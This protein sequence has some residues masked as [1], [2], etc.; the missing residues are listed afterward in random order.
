MLLNEK[1]ENIA[2]VLVD[3]DHDESD[4][5]EE[6]FLF[7]LSDNDFVTAEWVSEFR[8]VSV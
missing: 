3:G 6:Y 2:L 8:P 7:S 5:N 4:T 1:W